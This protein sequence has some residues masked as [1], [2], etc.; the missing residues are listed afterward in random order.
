M[1]L[2]EKITTRGMRSGIAEAAIAGRRDVEM[3]AT[4]TAGR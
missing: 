4:S 2:S 3:A 1:I